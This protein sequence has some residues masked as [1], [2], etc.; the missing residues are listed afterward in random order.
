[1]KYTYLLFGYALFALFGS[2]GCLHF[3]QGPFDDEPADATFRHVEETRVRY[4]D[5]GEGPTVVLLHG[6]AASLNTWDP[7]LPYLEEHFRVIALDLRGFGFT[8]RPEKGDYSPAGQA[9]LVLALLEELQVDTFHIVAH[10]WGSS[11]ALQMALDHPARI[12]RLAIF[13]GWVYEE[14]LP[15]FFLWSRANGVGELLFRLF[16]KERP[17]DKI[18]LAFY[19]QSHV[20]QELVDETKAALDRPG[21]LAAALEAVR[22]QRYEEIEARYST[23]EQ[24]VLLIWGR[25]DGVTRLSAGERLLRELPNARLVVLPGV[26]HFPMIEATGP[27]K[28]A[29]LPFLKGWEG[30]R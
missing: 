7:L 24:E 1:M 14:Q 4:I 28:N 6:F 13:D 9:N 12:Q 19:D 29:L 2:T 23:I 21:T 5:R 25:E 17:G 8:D 27:S 30:E 11:V 15:T 26:G 16:Y 10:S 22:G 3:H 18:S 20:T